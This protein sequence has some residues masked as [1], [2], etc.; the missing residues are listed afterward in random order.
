MRNKDAFSGCH[1]LVNFLYFGLTIGFSMFFMQPSCLLISLVCGICYY[2]SLKGR[3]AVSFLVR[4]ALPVMAAAA[5]INPVFNHQGRTILCYLPTGNPL[6][7]ESIL[8]GAAAA[9]MLVAVLIWFACYTEVMTSDKF[10]YLFGRIIPSLSLLLSMTLRFVPKFKAQ[11]DRV[12]EAQAAVG[13]DMSNGSVMHRIKCAAVCFSAMITWSLENAIETAD[14]MKGRGWGL[15]GRTAFSIYSFT[16][17]DKYILLWLAFCGIYIISGSLCGDIYWR[18]FPD[19]RAAALGVRGISFQV[20]YFA[21]CIT[22]ILIN[23]REEKKWRQ[24]RSLSGI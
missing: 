10:V 16:A 14:S 5:I 20:V 6:T 9:V 19:I 7:L 12:K 23:G 18:Y 11:F 22:P 1:P 3:R 21:M 4:A 2:I 17:R 13:R 15:R 24:S 8:Y